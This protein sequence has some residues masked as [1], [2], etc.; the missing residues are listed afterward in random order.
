MSMFGTSTPKWV[1]DRGGASEHIILFD[2]VYDLNAKPKSIYIEHT[3]EIDA[4]RDFIL[5]GTHWE[6]E[7]KMN[8]YKYSTNPTIVR[9][10]YNDINS[11]V[12]KKGT[13]WLHR[14]GSQYKVT[15]GNDA[16]FVLKECIPFYKET[17][18]Y[19]DG[20]IIKLESCSPVDLNQGSLPSYQL[21]NIVMSN[22]F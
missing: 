17:V 18:S 14:D 6:I 9:A 1:Y 22:D 12:G 7:F 10:K 5:K 20:L 8:L 3:S 21:A 4:E 15:N 16:L 2:Y 11:Y 13:F 19:K